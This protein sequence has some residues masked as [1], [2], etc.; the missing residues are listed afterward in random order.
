MVLTVL[1][2]VLWKEVNCN[3]QILQFNRIH[4]QILTKYIF[5]NQSEHDSM[6]ILFSKT[7][8]SQGLF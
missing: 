2:Y 3:L 5:T 7:P 6:F 8:L 1:K 4:T